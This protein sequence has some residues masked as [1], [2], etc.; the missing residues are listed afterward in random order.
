MESGGGGGSDKGD[1]GTCSLSTVSPL[2]MRRSCRAS[3]FCASSGSPSSSSFRILLLQRVVYL[4][5]RKYLQALQTDADHHVG[6]IEAKTPSPS[7]AAPP[8]RALQMDHES[9]QEEIHN[10]AG[11]HCPRNEF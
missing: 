6:G 9:K 8:S 10:D 4:R 3:I 1:K 11:Q 5:I 7:L 2:R